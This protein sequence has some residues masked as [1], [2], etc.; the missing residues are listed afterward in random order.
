[1]VCLSHAHHARSTQAASPIGDAPMSSSPAYLTSAPFGGLSNGDGA[2]IGSP[3]TA[4]SEDGID[5]PSKGLLPQLIDVLH[6]LTEGQE[7]LSRKVRDARLEHACHSSLAAERRPDD[8][9]SDF[10]AQ[11]VL[12]GTSPIASLGIRQGTPK[13]NV[14]LGAGPTSV[15]GN[16]NGNGNGS[17]PEPSTG[18]SATPVSATVPVASSPSN[19]PAAIVTHAGTPAD[20]SSETTRTDWLNSA[21]PIETNTAPLNRDY[22]YFD[23]LDARLADLQGPAAPS[24]E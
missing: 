10:A 8:T 20:P 23:E 21:R 11:H 2:D 5:V 6:A 3:V 15:N 17:L 13:N 14:E 9:P 7:L 22:N 24:G 18:I 4:R 19:P 1:M 12:V 16:G